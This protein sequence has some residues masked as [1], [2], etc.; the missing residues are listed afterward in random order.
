NGEIIGSERIDESLLEE[1]RKQEGLKGVVEEFVEESPIQ[2][3]MIEVAS[4][5]DSSVEA[6]GEEEWKSGNT[7]F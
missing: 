3:P 5:G 1:I 2:S 6:G 4:E 7:L